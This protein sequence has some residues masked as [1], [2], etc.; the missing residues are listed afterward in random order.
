MLQKYSNAIDWIYP[1]Q[2]VIGNGLLWTR[3]WT[4]GLH[5]MMRYSRMMASPEGIDRME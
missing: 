2:V 4:F 5:N 1:A 3:K